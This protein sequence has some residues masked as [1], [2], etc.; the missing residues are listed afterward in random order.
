MKKLSNKII[1]FVLV[2]L[3]TLGFSG[4]Q[5]TNAYYNDIE[6]S[7]GNS[8]SAAMLDFILTNNNL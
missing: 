5:Q 6:S 1:A 4:A 2:S 3:L 8:F 7:E